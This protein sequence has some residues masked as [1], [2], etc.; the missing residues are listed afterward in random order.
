MPQ[1][2]TLRTVWLNLPAPRWR[3]SMTGQ[4]FSSTWQP[5]NSSTLN[6]RP[7]VLCNIR[8][9][10]GCYAKK[11]K[12]RS[13]WRTAAAQP[14]PQIAYGRKDRFASKAPDILI[15]AR[16]LQWSRDIMSLSTP[17]SLTFFTSYGTNRSA[18]P[19]L[20]ATT[21]VTSVSTAG[22]SDST[23]TGFSNGATPVP[24]HTWTQ[25]ANSY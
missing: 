22:I 10:E 14:L 6:E 7:Q 8:L 5:L 1:Q 4:V 16:E 15:L 23:I 11:E 19:S 3:P 12:K 20:V 17:T 2:W 24:V 9:T 21:S 13:K 18:F 25:E